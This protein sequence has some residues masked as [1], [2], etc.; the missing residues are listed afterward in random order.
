MNDNLE[1]VSSMLRQ[2]RYHGHFDNPQNEAGTFSRLSCD[3]W[4]RSLSFQS[5][6]YTVAGMQFHQRVFQCVS[7]PPRPSQPFL[8]STAGKSC[9]QALT[10]FIVKDPLPVAHLAAWSLPVL[11][12][13]LV[14]LP[15]IADVLCIGAWYEPAIGFSLASRTLG[16]YDGIRSVLSSYC[17]CRVHTLSSSHL[18]INPRRG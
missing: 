1:L 15:P 11:R 5:K 18:G 17:T 7:T 16:F 4:C 13:F 10:T 8:N 3:D 9:R 12:H 14:Q 6:A 2:Y